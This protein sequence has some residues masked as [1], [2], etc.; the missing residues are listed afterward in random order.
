MH[1]VSQ[2]RP[3]WLSD[4]HKVIDHIDVLLTALDGIRQAG[5]P[6]E[7]EPTPGRAYR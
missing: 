7:V 3:A 2:G 1:E 6:V 4:G 5:H